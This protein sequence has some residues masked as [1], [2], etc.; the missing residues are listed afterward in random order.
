[1]CSLWQQIDTLGA[2][3]SV[4]DNCNNGNGN[5]NPYEPLVGS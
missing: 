4:Y 1:M 3:V 2:A 5:C